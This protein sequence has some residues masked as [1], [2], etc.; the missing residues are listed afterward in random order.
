MLGWAG[1]T[2]FLL[3]IEYWC[4]DPKVLPRYT[5]STWNV[6]QITSYLKK[7]DFA[8]PYSPPGIPSQ[9]DRCENGRVFREVYGGKARRQCTH[10]VN[11]HNIYC[12][13]G[14]IEER[15]QTRVKKVHQWNDLGLYS[16]PGIWRHA[17]C[18]AII[19]THFW[20]W[21]SQNLWEIFRTETWRKFLSSKCPR[22]NEW[23]KLMVIC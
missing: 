4:F 19:D 2:C 10:S 12:N 7:T 15:F 16:P 11:I 9:Y 22:M 8:C 13:D 18:N 5:K 1:R 21:L 17:I 14:G 3:T 23:R 6:A 20:G